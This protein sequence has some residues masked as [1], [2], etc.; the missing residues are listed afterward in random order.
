[1]KLY[2]TYLSKIFQEDID[3]TNLYDYQSLELD[4]N[5]TK[6]DLNILG[7]YLKKMKQYEEPDN[8]LDPYKWVYCPGPKIL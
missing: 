1:M 7:K 4:S 6:Q 8:P 2:E 3:Y 5:I